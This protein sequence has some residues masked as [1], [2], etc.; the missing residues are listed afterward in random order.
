MLGADH[1]QSHAL[2]AEAQ[3]GFLELG[4]EELPE[5]SGV[6]AGLGGAEWDVEGLK[7]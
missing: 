2:D 5:M 6:G 4:F 7:V 3:V 1:Q